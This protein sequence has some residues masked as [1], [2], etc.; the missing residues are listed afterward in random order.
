[1]NGALINRINILVDC[2]L[3]EWMIG[4]CSATCGSKAFRT[5]TRQIIQKAAYGGKTCD[6]TRITENCGLSECPS[7]CYLSYLYRI[8]MKYQNYV[9]I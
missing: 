2:K 5:K 9:Q 6:K 4:K 8:Y 7:K 3:G 1:M